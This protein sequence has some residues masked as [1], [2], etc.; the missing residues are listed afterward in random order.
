[1][2]CVMC[3]GQESLNNDAV[4]K[5]VKA[6]IED[7]VIGVIKQQPGNYSTSANDLVALKSAGLSDKVIAAMILKSSSGE[8]PRSAPAASANGGTGDA[9][10][11]GEV[12][13]YYKKAGAWTEVLPE[14][15]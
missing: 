10:A 8:A 7:V 6:G 2:L 12:G 11:F 1:M 9:A 5:L 14:I 4:I 13:V 3:P 15:V